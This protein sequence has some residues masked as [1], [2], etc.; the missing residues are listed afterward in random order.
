MKP[1][2][3]AILAGL[4]SPVINASTWSMPRRSPSSEGSKSANRS[5]AARGTFASMIR[6]LAITSDR[7][8]EVA[9]ACGDARDAGIVRING[10]SLEAIPKGH[11]LFLFNREICSSVLGRIQLSSAITI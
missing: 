8:S 6:V 11:M 4:L 7:E 3:Q 2:T 10:F 9:G 1:I 5:R